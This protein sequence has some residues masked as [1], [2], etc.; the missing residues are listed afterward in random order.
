MPICP[1]I[2]FF[3]FFLSLWNLLVKNIQVSGTCNGANL[4][5]RIQN[6]S[7]IEYSEF[8]FRIGTF[9]GNIDFTIDKIFPSNTI[10]WIKIVPDSNISSSTT[11]CGISTLVNG[12]LY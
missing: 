7:D 6:S 11:N 9:G 4:H 8:V 2:L 1:Y 10:I 12:V 3:Y 5:L